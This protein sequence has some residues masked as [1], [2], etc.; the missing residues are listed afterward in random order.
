MVTRISAG[1]QAEAGQQKVRATMDRQRPRSRFPELEPLPPGTKRNPWYKEKPSFRYVPRSKDG[2]TFAPHLNSQNWVFVKKEVDDFRKGCPPCG[3]MITR[4][5]KDAPFPLI[6]RTKATPAPK[7]CQKKASKN[8]TLFS[9][10]SAA[11]L[12][13][14]A[15]VEETEASLK[16]K[17]HPLEDCPDL[18]DALPAELLE[19][20]LEVLDPDKELKDTWAYCQD[21]KKR[22]KDPAELLK[23]RPLKPCRSLRNLAPIP[24]PD[25]WLKEMKQVEEPP[26]HPPTPENVSRAVAD[27][28]RW[29]HSYECTDIDKDYMMRK[30]DPFVGWK[31]NTGRSH[32]KEVARI[33]KSLRKVHWPARQDQPRFSLN[34]P[35][36]EKKL[37]A[38][39]LAPPKEPVKMRYGAWYLPV[40]LWKKLRVDEPLLDPNAPEEDEDTGFRRLDN[41]PDILEEL[42]GTIAFKDFILS[43]GYPMPSIIERMFKRKKWTYDKVKTPTILSR[44]PSPIDD[45]PEEEQ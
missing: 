17:A 12:A 1:Q 16:A 21:G 30:F 44:K 33:P 29:A 13:R 22:T 32:I 6:Y 31:A 7:T 11:Q 8:S 19:K 35:D 4:G 24:D 20:V 42:Y 23:D 3:E 9:K 34:E 39:Q 45:A 10:L 37:Q 14:K 36:F 38:L 15:F 2:P 25:E 43:K 27:F 26:P 41:G 40:K 5:C 28:C 18:E